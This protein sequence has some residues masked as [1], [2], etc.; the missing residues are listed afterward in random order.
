MDEGLRLA[1]SLFQPTL[2]RMTTT[3]AP[4]TPLA[5]PRV[6]FWDVNP[7]KLDVEKH[8]PLIIGRVVERGTLSDWH[9]VRRHY[10]DARMIKIVTNLRDLHPQAVSLCCA[11]FSLT[12]DD[13]RCCTARPF[14]PAPWIY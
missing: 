9:T 4:V 14:P 8:A 7:E 1:I 11:A 6:L 3:T 5:L 2:R 12:R 10:G 13:F